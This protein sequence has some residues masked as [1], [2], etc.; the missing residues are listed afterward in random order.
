MKIFWRIFLS[1]WLASVAIMFAT[2]YVVIHKLEGTRVVEQH[3]KHVSTL[4]LKLIALYEAGE[5]IPR[6]VHRM[7]ASP[8]PG[9]PNARMPPMPLEFKIEVEDGTPVFQRRFRQ[10][11]NSETIEI[12][13]SSSSGQRYIVYTN[14]PML[15]RFFRDVITRT[16]SL[17][18][19]LILIFSTLVSVLLSWSITHP[20][21][22]LGR[23]SRR[24]ALGE[25]ATIDT[26]ILKRGDELGDLAKDLDYMSET[27]RATLASQQQLLH[28]V[29]HE[30][31]APLAR[32]QASVALVEKNNT[33]T[34]H[35]ER[36]HRECGRINALIQQILD[37]SRLNRDTEKR[38]IQNIVSLVKYQLESLR[39]EF[40]QRQF[41][42]ES[43]QGPIDI[44]IFPSALQGALDN[45]LR[46]ACRYAPQNTPIELTIKHTESNAKKVNITIRDHGPGVKKEELEKI[47]KPFYRGGQQMHTEGFGLGL[48]IAQKAL[49]KHNGQLH[50][51]NHP[52]GGLEVEMTFG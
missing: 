26:A 12:S 15:P 11:R 37:F 33:A 2:A 7:L 32:L 29:S 8:D 48:S 22:N 13:L 34:S 27:I 35:T 41:L 46:N 19:V 45:I 18:F 4:A 36:M 24:F 52:E 42:L 25:S 21:K 9:Q 51:R 38:E 23:Y 30:L 10:H 6:R 20:L 39:F 40:P 47:L 43:P 3:Q 1:F 44:A 14:K 49:A 5:P 50:L 16:Y 28:D 17:Q 31:R